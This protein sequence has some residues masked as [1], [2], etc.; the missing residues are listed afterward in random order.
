MA[1]YRLLLCLALLMT[2]ASNCLALLGPM[3]SG[4]AVDAI[5]PNMGAEDF[6][7]VFY[8]AGLMVVFYVGSAVLSYALSV[9][10]VTIGRRVVYQM[11][12]DVFERMLALR[13]AIMTRTRPAI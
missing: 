13:W 2:A 12:K 1:R 11:R 3:L 6:D 10:M 8:Y 5:H 4:Y 7:R 9:L